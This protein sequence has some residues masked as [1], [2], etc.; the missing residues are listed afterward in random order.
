MPKVDALNSLKIK[1]ILLLPV[2]NQVEN[3]DDILLFE[4]M[5]FLAIE[6]ARLFC[7]NAGVTLS[8]RVWIR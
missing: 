3:C 4:G 1:E 5:A 8:T 2:I 7:S 6:R